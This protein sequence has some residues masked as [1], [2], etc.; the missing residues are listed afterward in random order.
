MKPLHPALLLLA[1]IAGTFAADESPGKPAGETIF[2][3][4]FTLNLH[5]DK[6]TSYEEK[7]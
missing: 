4:P 2:R 6:Q 3:D 7:V 1:C 5:I